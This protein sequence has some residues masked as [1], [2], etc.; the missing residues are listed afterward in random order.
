MISV[1]AANVGGRVHEDLQEAIHDQWFDLDAARFE[2]ERR[3][4]RLLL[5]MTRMGPFDSELRVDGVSGMRVDDR[6][7]I[8]IYDLNEIVF[9]LEKGRIYLRSAFPLEIVLS[10]SEG[11]ELIYG[12]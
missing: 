12:Q 10:V 11:W 3:V 7:G 6:A 2:T 9:E 4:F 8:Q 5:G 1:A